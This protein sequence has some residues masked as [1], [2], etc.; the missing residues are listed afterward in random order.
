MMFSDNDPNAAEKFHEMF[1]P[2]QVDQAV[3]QAIQFC[4]VTLPKDRPSVD[5]LDYPDS[6]TCRSGDQGLPR[7]S[8]GVRQTSISI[9]AYGGA[10]PAR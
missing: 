1:G 3:R 4:W 6:P 9:S 5:E 10:P 2:E 7:R 8:Q